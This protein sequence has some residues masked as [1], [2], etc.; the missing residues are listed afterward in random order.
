[1]TLG[2][3]VPDGTELGNWSLSSPLGKGITVSR[4]PRN[5]IGEVGGGGDVQVQGRES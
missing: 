1:M 5:G 2:H 3:E 4:P